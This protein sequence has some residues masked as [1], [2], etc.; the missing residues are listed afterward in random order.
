MKYRKGRRFASAYFR[1]RAWHG[2]VSY[3]GVRHVLGPF[4]LE[5]DAAQARDDKNRSLLGCKARLNFPGAD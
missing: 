1:A 3:D 4:K 5:R 2:R